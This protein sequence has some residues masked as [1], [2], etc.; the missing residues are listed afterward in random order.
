MTQARYTVT[1]TEN[2]NILATGQVPETSGKTWNRFIDGLNHLG[3]FLQVRHPNETSAINLKNKAS[4]SKASVE[5]VEP[6]EIG[7]YEIPYKDRGEDKTLLLR[8]D[9]DPIKT[10]RL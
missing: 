9:H 8:I 5:P 7:K 1:G 2:G 6:G 3:I 10:K 4:R